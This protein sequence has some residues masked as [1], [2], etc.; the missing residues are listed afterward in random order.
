VVPVLSISL[1]MDS[2]AWTLITRLVQLSHLVSLKVRFFLIDY[3]QSQGHLFLHPL[4]PRIHATTISFP[5]N[6]ATAHCTICMI[7]FIPTGMLSPL[8]THP[9]FHV[10]LEALC[11]VFN[12]VGLPQRPFCCGFSLYIFL[13]RYFPHLHFQCYPKSLPYPPHSP[14]H[15]LPLFGP[16]V[17]LYWGI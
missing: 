12:Y 9:S 15:P 13:I 4:F 14:T 17:P 5:T 1:Y 10:C 16:G 7:S 6:A 11:L 3:V 8:S 2:G